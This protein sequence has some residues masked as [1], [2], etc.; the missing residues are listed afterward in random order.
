M[1]FLCI[2]TDLALT[3][4][5]MVHWAVFP[6]ASAGMRHVQKNYII[7]IDLD[8]PG[9][10]DLDGNGTI[11]SIDKLAFKKMRLN[12]VHIHELP[13]AKSVSKCY[14]VITH[15]S[16]RLHFEISPFGFAMLQSDEMCSIAI[17]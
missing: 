13:H 17:Q 7:Y 9:F 5:I 15:H 2:A 3:N 11:C 12:F 16:Q 14:R 10:I 6:S 8:F 4:K 1:V